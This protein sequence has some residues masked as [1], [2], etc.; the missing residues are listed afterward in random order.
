VIVG[1]CKHDGRG[2]IVKRLIVCASIIAIGLAAPLA[3]VAAAPANPPAKPKAERLKADVEKRV[4]FGT[5]H[6]L[7]S[8]TRNIS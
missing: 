2:N 6:T 4:S 8:A 5:R 3:A 1:I 7:S